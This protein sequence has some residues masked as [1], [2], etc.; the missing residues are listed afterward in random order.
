L[1]WAVGYAQNS[2]MQLGQKLMSR[3]TRR[4]R[5]QTMILVAV[6][7]VSLLAMAALA[8]DV[9]TLYVASTEIQRAADAAALAG[10]KAMADSG[11]TTLPS[12][13]PNFGAALILAESM[14]TSATAAVL[15]APN[16]QVAGLALA[17]APIFNVTPNAGGA[18]NNPRVTVTLQRTGLPTFFAHIW[19]ATTAG[20]TASA[21]AEAYNPANM[22][23]YTQISPKGVKPWLVANKD[24]TTPAPYS[25]FVNP[26]TGDIELGAISEDFWL[27]A[28]CPTVG[29]GRSRCAPPLP[30]TPPGVAAIPEGLAVQYLPAAVTANTADVCNASCGS[31]SD[32]Q[33]SI[34]CADMS[35]YQ[36]GGEPTTNNQW[37]MVDRINPNGP[38]FTSR[39]TTDG[40]KCLIHAGGPGPGQGQDAINLGTWPTNPMQI[41]PSGSTNLMSTSSSIVAIPI[42]D[43]NPADADFNAATGAVTVIG[44]LQAFI[45]QFDGANN[46][47]IKVMNV[48]GC[49]Q[50]AGGGTTVVG[51]NT[52]SPI[53][54]RLITPP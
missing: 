20:V 10:A 8:I 28:D 16:N 17:G 27:T 13:D 45:E 47:E 2:G 25:N 51:G 38:F 30:K 36:C 52:S 9:V 14:A 1:T 15:A 37:D 33:T 41:T 29:F 24:P 11:L 3:E 35:P 46:I 49:G 12:S 31:A 7:I 19:G 6:S 21:T 26:V 22:A 34:Q 53:P 48:V 23:S 5:G 32:Y 42:I 18:I 54:V 43:V 39:D 4:Q 50:T 44:F 40:L